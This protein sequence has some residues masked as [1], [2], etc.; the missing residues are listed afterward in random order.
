MNNKQDFLRIIRQEVCLAL[1]DPDQ[2]ILASVQVFILQKA[3]TYT[4]VCETYGDKPLILDFYN[5]L[6]DDSTLK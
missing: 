4:E 6:F 5:Y 3:L 2:R 1:P